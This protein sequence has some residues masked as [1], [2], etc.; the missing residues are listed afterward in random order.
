MALNQG[1]VGFDVE[2]CLIAALVFLKALSSSFPV[3]SH[4]GRLSLSTYLEWDN[5]VQAG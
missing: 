1:S 2:N 5:P 4:T 3:V